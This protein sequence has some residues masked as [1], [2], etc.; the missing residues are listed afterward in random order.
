MYRNAIL[1]TIVATTAFTNVQAQ[2]G[3]F[4]GFKGQADVNAILSSG[5][6]DKSTYGA[7]IKGTREWNVWSLD[8]NASANGGESDGTRDTE[9]YNFGL[10]GNRQ[11]IDDKTY[12]FAGAT[13]EIDNFSGFDFLATQTV[14]LGRQFIENDVYTLKGQLGI[15]AQ[16]FETDAGDSTEEF[17]VRPEANF[18]WNITDTLQFTQ[19]LGAI[20]GSDLTTLKSKTAIRNQ[21]AGNLFLQAAYELEN[22]SDV[23]AGSDSTDAKTTLGLSY[24]F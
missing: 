8:A 23:P 9:E 20:I 10:Q 1:A 16:E 6:T 24:G 18:G 21:L 4:L 3:N 22:R 5:N 2:E 7:A 15:G 14:G 13:Y 12:A 19:D 17:V 11:I